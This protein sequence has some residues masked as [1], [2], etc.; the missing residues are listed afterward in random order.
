MEVIVR[1]EEPADHPAVR[2]LLDEAFGQP[3]EG[4]LVVRLRAH[5]AFIP[6]LS[7]VAVADGLV[8][9]YLLLFP[10]T[11]EGVGT[12]TQSLALAPMAVAPALQR[13][14]IGSRLVEDAAARACTL[15]YGSII[16][17]GHPGY[18][19]RFGFRPASRWGIRAPFPVPDEAFL[20]LE[21]LPAALA[22][23]AGTV[24]YPEE[25]GAL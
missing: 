6:A 17:V 18:Y 16:V 23:A 9:G 22:G 15:G 7:L 12:R 19:S 13:K 25:F 5:P 2:R 14:G 10:V 8:A 11:I 3:G 4:L 21:L 24:R 20:A 1:P